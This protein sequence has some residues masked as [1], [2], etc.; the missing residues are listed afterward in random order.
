[1]LSQA[2][3]HLSSDSSDPEYKAIAMFRLDQLSIYL[4]TV[5]STEFHS[6][7]PSGVSECKSPGPKHISSSTKTRQ[8]GA[9]SAALKFAIRQVATYKKNIE[10]RKVLRQQVI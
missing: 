7:P 10:E 3:L 4:Q 5:Q 9:S 1:M 8:G 6:F 2:L